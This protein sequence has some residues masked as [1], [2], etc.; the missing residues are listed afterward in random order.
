MIDRPNV[1]NNGNRQL[2]LKPN[3]ALEITAQNG[4]SANGTSGHSGNQDRSTLSAP[5]QVSQSKVAEPGK[6]PINNLNHQLLQV[7]L[8][9]T[10]IPLAVAGTLGYG[11]SQHQ[12]ENQGK[13]QLQERSLSARRETTALLANAIQ[14]PEMIATNPLVINAARESSQQVKDLDLDRLP[15]DQIE[16]RFSSTKL[17]NPNQNLNDYL[18]K[19]ADTTGIAALA[20]TEQ[21]GLNIAASGSQPDLVQRDKQWWQ[22]GQINTKWI[23]EPEINRSTNGV[24]VNLAHAILNPVSGEFLGVVQAVLPASIF[25]QL[26]NNLNLSDQSNSQ[27]IQLLSA[28]GKVIMTLTGQTAR[29][30]QSITGGEAVQKL[31]AALV[32]ALG[33]Q[34]DPQQAANQISGKYSLQ[35]LTIAPL[36]QEKG[37]P[38]LLVSFNH[39]DRRYSLAT[40]P[41]TNWVAVASINQSELTT[42]NYELLILILGFLLLGGTAIAAT[43]YLSR[44]L[45]LPLRY[46]TSAAGQVASGQL[47]QVAIPNSTQEVQALAQ[48]LNQLAAKTKSVL[49]EQVTKAEWANILTEVTN[50]RILTAREIEPVFDKAL[51]KA[52]QALAVDRIVIYRFN[53]DW[54]GYISNESVSSGWSHALNEK[55][56][57]ACIPQ[58]LLE[59]YRNDRVVATRDVLN[60]GFHPDHLQLMRQLQIKANLVVPIISSGQ[61]FGLL[62]AH[63]C[64]TTYDWQESEIDFMRQLAIQLGLIIDRVTFL[65]S[66]KAIAERSQYFRDITIEIMRPQTPEVALS[67]LPLLQIRQALKTDRVVVYRFDSDWKGTVTAESVGDGW[68]KALN[69]E[70]YDPCFEK[71]YVE[72]YKRG[73]V[74]ATSNIQKAGLT[75]CHLKQLEPFAVKANLVAPIIQGEQLLGL[76]IAHQC[77]KPRS[78]EQA[79]ID[80]FAQIAVQ[81]GLALDRCTL[82]D[83]REIAAKQSR[84]LAEEQ[85]Q[86]KEELQQQLVDL[87]NQIEGAA[88]G[89]LTVRAEVNAGAIGTVADFF[90]VIV[91]SLR[92]IVTQVQQSALQVNASIGEN[93]SAIRQLADTALHQAEEMTQNLDLVEQMTQTIR[94]IADSAHQATQVAHQ[95]STTAAAGGAA[96][97]LTVENI[98]SL[99]QTI[100]ETAKK[101]KTLGESS[102]Q[103]SKVVSLINQFSMQTNLLAIN[104]GIEAAR[105]GEDGQGFS[106][107][108]EEIGELASR[109]A[110][111]TQEIEQII[112]SI[113]VGTRQVVAAMEQSTTQVVEGTRLVEDTKHSLGQIM[114]ESRQIDQFV[115]SIS[116]A[117]ESQVQISQAVS[118]L[119]KEIAHAAEDTSK[120]S[121]QLSG[122]LRQTVAVSQELQSS[123]STFK[124]D[125]VKMNA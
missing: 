30:T 6:L 112:D 36:P 20:F 49:Q 65:Q 43:L 61:L 3:S 7:I 27:Q 42:M 81:I 100:G 102:Q 93:E 67:Q 111:A 63:H 15:V 32:K 78:W 92:H 34:S 114:E 85:R 58:I 60:A 64:A 97:D 57:D 73:R 45:T 56:E 50:S 123:V 29:N 84:L 37:E 35:D 96:M 26:A 120:V 33:E 104:A 12:A 101:V 40:I 23:S 79:E 121:H 119:M 16:R 53:E 125:A 110:T 66:Q 91:E 99:R 103:I 115:Q 21:H 10:L 70:I 113:Q 5:N 69:A 77:S 68:T 25:A 22:K 28:T 2:H 106:V 46:L 38:A 14:V 75:E 18:R 86:E 76:L 95:A 72:K 44:R 11:I 59:G 117:T 83:Q 89:D 47:D 90:N 55:I 24:N 39:A 17:L 108:A 94:S 51:V 88:E 1:T 87:L 71:S 19:T 124:V 48:I 107:I 109:S 74:Q 116:A 9:T 105:A 13:L 52:Q 80:F 41:Q 98:L 31:S 118:N 54:S 62:I 82:L 4:F 8:P 122:S